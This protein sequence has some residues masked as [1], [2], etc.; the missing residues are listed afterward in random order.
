[1]RHIDNPSEIKLVRRANEGHRPI[2]DRDELKQTP[3]DMRG[4]AYY[5]RK[6]SILYNSSHPIDLREVENYQITRHRFDTH[7]VMAGSARSLNDRF[8]SHNG[9]KDAVILDRDEREKEYQRIP[10]SRGYISSRSRS[11]SGDRDFRSD[12]YLDVKPSSNSRSEYQ[13]LPIDPPESRSSIPYSHR[14]SSMPVDARHK[15]NVKKSDRETHSSLRSD[16]KSHYLPESRHYS[17]MPPSRVERRE[18]HSPLPEPHKWDYKSRS[19]SRDKFTDISR[20]FEKLNYKSWADKPDISPKSS[21]YFGEPREASSSYSSRGSSR[22][23]RT[24]RGF[25]TRGFRGP[26]RGNTYYRGSFRGYRSSSSPRGR[27]IPRR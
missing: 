16:S 14:K 7:D 6:P 23:F 8:P 3:R 5:E 12:R 17:D 13:R 21:D 19:P 26:M 4:E 10:V 15:L 18:H 11:R 1:M 20:R 24:S 25:R 22:P 27:G 9:R 2:F